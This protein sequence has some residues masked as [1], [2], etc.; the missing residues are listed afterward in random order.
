LKKEATERV[1]ENA[2][3]MRE[4]TIRRHVRGERRDAYLYSI[5]R[6]EWKEPKILT[7]TA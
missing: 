7:R 1:L 4:G 2:G 5:L 3:F 6:E